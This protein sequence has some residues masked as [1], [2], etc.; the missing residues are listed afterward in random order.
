MCFWCSSTRK[1]QDEISEYSFVISAS[2]LV[3]LLQSQ[4]G[5]INPAWERRVGFNG[6][7]Y[8]FHRVIASDFHLFVLREHY[9][10]NI[11]SHRILSVYHISNLLST[12]NPPDYNRLRPLVRS[13]F[14]YTW[15]MFLKL[16]FP[17]RNTSIFITHLILFSL[18]RNYITLGENTFIKSQWNYY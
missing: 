11:F 3:L 6:V 7:L 13:P 12:D 16:L 18:T 17:F 14:K 4:N 2:N 15:L 9:H 8:I 5:H 10:I 1:F